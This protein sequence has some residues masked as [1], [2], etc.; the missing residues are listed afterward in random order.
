M[1]RCVAF[2]D[3]SNVCMIFELQVNSPLNMLYIHREPGGY[4][5]LNYTTTNCLAFTSVKW[6][7]LKKYSNATWDINKCSA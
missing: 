7:V 6:H 3:K 1:E 4:I 5:Y 2:S